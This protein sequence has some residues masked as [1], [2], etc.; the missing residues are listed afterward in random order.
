MQKLR[1]S[2]E[3]DNLPYGKELLLTR[4]QLLMYLD[5]SSVEADGPASR[6]LPPAPLPPVV[7]TLPHRAPLLTSDDDRSSSAD[8]LPPSGLKL[9]WNV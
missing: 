6:H 5:R 7:L 1:S 3:D 8:L 2:W 9:C 4:R